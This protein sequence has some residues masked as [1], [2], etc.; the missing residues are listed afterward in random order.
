M[1]RPGQKHKWRALIIGF[2][3]L[4]LIA[5]GCNGT[6]DENLPDS[7]NEEKT[8]VAVSI[9]PQETFV[10]AVGGD[11]VEVITMVPPGA[12]TANYS[13]SP[14]TLQDLAQARIYFSI[15]VPAEKNILPKFEQINKELKLVDLAARVD[16]VYP[17][18][19]IAAGQRDPHC[20]MSPRRVIQMVKIIAD[21][22]S[23]LSPQNADYFRE[24]AADY[25]AQLEQLDQDIQAALSNPPRRN[26]I[27]YHPSM[28]YFADD[29]ELEMIALE[30]EGK[31]ATA[32]DFQELID[33]ARAENIKVVFYQAEMDGKQAQSLAA[34]IG[35]RA[36]LIAPLAPDY[37]DNLRKTAVVFS[38]VLKEE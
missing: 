2:A 7:D 17:P 23:G 16:A 3:L 37:I 36:E 8:C 31:A 25:C 6:Q 33:F 29:Y 30:K 20:W 18:R 27:V 14:K 22:L 12:S 11:L 5:A 4:L 21:E 1:I 28:G 34:E 9:L 26:F 35:G 13:P 15:A 24:N 32:K 38:S 19:E 10:R